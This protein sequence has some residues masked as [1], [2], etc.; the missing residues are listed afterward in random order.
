MNLT[1]LVA[2]PA[3]V[4]DGAI[5]CDPINLLPSGVPHVA[6]PDLVR[7][8]PYGEAKWLLEPVG[9]D[10]SRVRVTASGQWVAWKCSPRPAVDADYRAVKS[11]R[12][13]TAPQIL[14]PERTSL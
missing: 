8:R 6:D 3:E 14:R 10:A 9:D 2:R 5:R 12:V 11:Y 7:T 4:L 1:A 13:A